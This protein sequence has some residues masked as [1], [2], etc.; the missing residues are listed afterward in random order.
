MTASAFKSLP[1]IDFS[2]AKN[3]ETKPKLLKELRYALFQVGFLY[4]INHGIEKEA[5]DIIDLAPK[6]F[7]IPQDVKDSVAMVRNPHFLG[8]SNLGAEITAN[9]IDVREQYDFTSATHRDPLLTDF[10]KADAE[11]T[12][13]PSFENPPKKIP[14]PWRRLQGPIDFPPEEVL[15]HFKQ[16][17]TTYLDSIEPLATN[18]IELVA[19]SLDLPS[20]TFKKF[21]AV[22]NHM[23]IVK[24]PSPIS[25]AKANDVADGTPLQGG[26]FFQGCGPHKDTSS[27][28]TFIVQNSIGGL[29]VQNQDGK[30]VS[31][32]PIPNSFVVNIAQGFEALTGGRCSATTH[33]V[34]SPPA[35]QTRYSVPYFHGIRL[36]VTRKEV[37][38]QF[39]LIREKVP[40]PVKINSDQTVFGASD[41]IGDTHAVLGDSYLNNRCRSHQDVAEIWY[42]R[43]HQ[44]YNLA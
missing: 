37:E 36:D 6:T 8:Y 21:E 35:N 32:D 27:L 20:D 40:A 26:Q 18:F 2:L 24:Y 14:E 38:D 11:G 44:L 25:D 31:A 4:L 41:L 29:Q 17:V 39:N 12:T 9:H 43:Y 23:K 1:I 16:V 3:P 15:P 7:E 19:E 13:L 5:Q 30:W 22:S 34:L 10:D 28:F 42:P 33:Q